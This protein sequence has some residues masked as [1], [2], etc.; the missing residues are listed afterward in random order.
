MSD[1]VEV[2]PD[3]VAGLK[4][5]VLELRTQIRKLTQDYNDL[6]NDYLWTR[7]QYMSLVARYFSASSE[8]NAVDP[9]Q[10]ALEF[11]EAEAHSTPAPIGPDAVTVVAEHERK[12]RGRKP[13][14]EDI[15]TV[16]VVH[17]LGDA[18][19]LCP[20]CGKTRPSM[21]A[22]ETVEFDLV[23]AHVVRKVH[24][25]MKYGSCHC[26][27]FAD[28]DAP[29]VVMG[30]PVPKIVPKS[31]FTNRTIAFFLTG[32]FEDAIPF[33]RMEK[34][35][36]RA[37]L[38][39]TRATL[40]NLAI[41][42]GRAIGDLIDAMW[43]D[44]LHSEVILTDE[45]TLQVLREPGRAAQTMSY[46]WLTMG[47]R[48]RRQISLFHYHPTRGKGVPETSLEGFSGYLQTDGYEGYASTGSRDGVI[49]VGCW[50]HIRRKFVDAQ[51]VAGPGGLADEA[52]AICNR[53]FEIERGLRTRLNAGAIT[54]DQFLEK[55][56]AK[57]EA[58]FSEFRVWLA[59]RSLE[60][61]RRT[62]LGEA[63]YYAQ[64]QIDKA[65]RFVDHLLLTPST[66]Q[67]E[68]GIRPFVVGRKGWLFNDTPLGAHASAGIFSLI[69][70]AK[71]NGHDPFR[72]LTYLFEQLPLA[73][74]L[75]E[76]LALLPY[77]LDPKSY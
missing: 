56:R 15:E 28:S 14:P 8:R 37:G 68:N 12:K 47:F 76:Q 72:Y 57:E 4:S 30:P 60:V 11:N 77:R 27:G 43:D 65:E 20:C 45:T 42:V 1:L 18:E 46:M 39:V 70:T 13:R 52:I 48:D 9:G 23:P 38:E 41:G 51:T 24:K 26:E 64:G 49:H 55:R 21:G 50:A 7:E 61:A 33:N 73:T 71:A 25:R 17:D 54:D 16:E 58:V 34:I 6:R 2:V 31:P 3:D 69:E 62:K 75:D 36:L 40:C 5:Q 22:E 67:V 35:L 66:N 10:K 19:K 32:K 53:V 74:T 63:I 44:I 59:R 29:A